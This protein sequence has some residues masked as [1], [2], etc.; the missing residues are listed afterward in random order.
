M[1]EGG[2]G[3]GRLGRTSY[4]PWVLLGAGHVDGVF[5]GVTLEVNVE[6]LQKKVR[7]SNS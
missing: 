7:S 6:L 3:N 2:G 4:A 5:A 1:G